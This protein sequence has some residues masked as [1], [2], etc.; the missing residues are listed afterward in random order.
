M[1][2]RLLEH[3]HQEEDHQLTV[4]VNL[5]KTHEGCPILDKLIQALKSIPKGKALGFIIGAP[6]IIGS[7]SPDNFQTI[8][9]QEHK[10]T[11]NMPFLKATIKLHMHVHDKSS[12]WSQ[13]Y[14]AQGSLSIAHGIQVNQLIQ[15]ILPFAHG[16]AC[17]VQLLRGGRCTPYNPSGLILLDA[18]EY[19]L[20][21]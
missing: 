15:L 13:T 3:M 21:L 2:L 12:L 17:E 11:Y 8:C 14:I 7:S 4:T 18:N 5:D 20:K 1:V 6:S 16:A 19:S 10:A 9:I